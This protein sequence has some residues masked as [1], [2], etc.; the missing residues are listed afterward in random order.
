MGDAH[1]MK[2]GNDYVPDETNKIRDEE[3]GKHFRSTPCK[4]GCSKWCSK[5]FWEGKLETFTFWIEE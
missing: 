1:Q 4:I 5:Y 2:S 3:N